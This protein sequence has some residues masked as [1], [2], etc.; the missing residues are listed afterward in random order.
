VKLRDVRLVAGKELRET[1]RD[2]RTLAVMVLFP[3]VV[4]PL[5]LL[6]T[7][8]VMADRATRT[9]STPSRIAVTGPEDIAAP[10]RARLATRPQQLRL[11]PGPM[12]GSEAVAT[13]RADAAVAASADGSG[14]PPGAKIFYD[15][16]R[17]ASRTARE[18]VEAALA[19]PRPNCPPAFT[20][21][22]QSIA[23]RTAVGGYV[24]SKIL[25]LIVVIMVM[26]GAFHPAID[27]TAGERERGT[28]ET[29]LSAP[30]DR[31]SLMAGKVLAV[32]TL[33]AITGLLN[34]ASMSLTVLQGARIATSHATFT[35]PWFRA[36]SV[37]LVIP[38]AAFLFASVMVAV[39]AMARSFKEAQTLL[40]PL[41]FLCTAPSMTAALGEFD[42]R[43]AAALFPGV[44]ITL[45]A[46]DLLLGQA[47]GSAVALV[48]GSTIAYGA[49]ALSVAARLY[50]SERLLGADEPGLG[51]GA[52]LRRLI[53]GGVDDHPS[54]TRAP[55]AAEALALYAVAWVLLV[56]FAEVQARNLP[57]GL[58]L[59]EWVGLGGLTLLYARGTGQRLT[60]VL[61]F[62][63]PSP[64]ALAGGIA[65]GLS[66]WLTVGL[67]ASWIAPA[68]KEIVDQLRRVIAPPSGDRSLAATLFLT[69][70]SPAIC[71]EALFRGPILLGLRERLRPAGAAIVTGIFFGLYHGDL[72]RLLPTGLLGALLSMIALAG[73]SIIPAMAAHFINNAM[74][75]LLAQH[76]LDQLDSLGTG[77]KIGLVAAGSAVLSLG[78]WLL[79]RARTQRVM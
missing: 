78:M 6:V 58:F 55:T 69:A 46:R 21:A 29:T 62:R 56:V 53:R 45:L 71:E 42:L 47:R 12:D 50:D 20:V 60:A 72:W 49:A 40:T 17:E 37:L 39:G 70:L 36:A 75:V 64:S 66:A 19:E 27:I 33:A 34:L 16:T 28:L 2:R 8:Q 38:P 5:V 35:L 67:I 59:F 63:R 11:L 43:G 25:P 1:L 65:I 77:P 74:L 54:E 32:A 24:L 61:R 79:A 48:L 9:E 14:R 22:A 15:E 10:I 57:L 3:L 30:V 7:T 31:P 73:D 4:Y 23:P 68:P 41:Y 26:L 13:A 18:R 44:N 51:L 76:E 52:W